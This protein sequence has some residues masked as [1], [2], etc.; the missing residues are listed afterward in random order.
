MCA[1]VAS[2]ASSNRHWSTLNL[3]S[4]F[5]SGL[6]SANS[7]SK[8]VRPHSLA[9]KQ[10]IFWNSISE[11]YCA[12]AQS[13]TNRKPPGQTLLMQR[14]IFQVIE[15]ERLA[16]MI[17]PRGQ[18]QVRINALFSLHWQ[19]QNSQ[20]QYLYWQIEIKE[21]MPCL[22]SVNWNVLWR[23]YSGTNVLNVQQ[24]IIQI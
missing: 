22:I 2:P 13:V 3:V 18:R 4:A 23:K 6:V 1:A 20:I 5:I 16:C 15:N 14:V 11:V 10:L 21:P 24:I 9:C 12:E 17:S 8:I 7:T 19:R